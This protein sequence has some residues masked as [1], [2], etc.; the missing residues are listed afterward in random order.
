MIIDDSPDALAVAKVRLDAEGHTIVCADGGKTGLDAV[1]RER[2]DLILLDV[3]MPGVSG[4]DVCRELKA[5]AELC[6]IPIIFLTGSIDTGNKVK[7]LDLGAVDYLTKPFDAFELRAR[8][9]AALRTKH[10][11]DLLLKYSQ[12]DPLTEL[13]NRRAMVERLHQEWAR[14]QRQSGTFGLVMA[15]VDY[16]K[17]VNDEHGHH[18]GDRMLCEVANVIRS[19]CRQSDL[20]VRYGGEEFAVILPGSDV[21]AAAALA[22]RCRAGIEAV[23][24][25]VAQAVV[26]TTASFG[27]ADSSGAPSAEAVVHHADKALYL[28]KS[29]GRNRVERASPPVEVNRE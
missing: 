28:A 17:R 25:R 7:G 29:N 24:L 15:D 2:P 4:F 1:R 13:W 6:L 18:V 26:R 11:Q 9:R 21:E 5:D 22:E 8:V 27:V 14:I 23:R 3:E 12:V 19:Q 10:L 16:F 20:P